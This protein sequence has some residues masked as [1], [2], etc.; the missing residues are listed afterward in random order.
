MQGNRMRFCLL[1]GNISV[2]LEV[3]RLFQNVKED[4]EGQTLN[5]Y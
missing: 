1:M 5:A 3:L 4:N 2:V